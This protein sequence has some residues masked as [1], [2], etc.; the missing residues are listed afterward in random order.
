MYR[1]SHTCNLVGI[2]PIR[3]TLFRLLPPWPIHHNKKT[4]CREWRNKINKAIKFL[5]QRTQTLSVV[6]KLKKI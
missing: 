3:E 6:T 5:L 4:I 2:H 1:Y